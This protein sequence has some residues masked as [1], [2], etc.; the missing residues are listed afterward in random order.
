MENKFRI[1]TD[2]YR[3]FSIQT[4]KWWFPFCWV[5]A[6][7]TSF[8]TIEKAKKRVEGLRKIVVA[9]DGKKIKFQE[10]QDFT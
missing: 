5:E 3:G 9:Q 6:C 7:V 1:R 4:K 10:S 8:E 2:Q